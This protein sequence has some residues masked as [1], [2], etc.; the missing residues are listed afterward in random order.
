LLT[1]PLPPPKPPERTRSASA[2]WSAEAQDF[3]PF[4]AS[5][6]SPLSVGAEPETFSNVWLSL[7]LFTWRTRCPAG[8]AQL[9]QHVSGN[10]IHATRERTLDGS[11]PAA[12]EAFSVS[13][14]DFGFTDANYDC[15]N[16]VDS[17]YK[18]SYGGKGLGRF[19]WLKAFEHVESDSHYRIAASGLLHRPLCVYRQR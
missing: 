9:V 5:S 11:R 18:A 17:P 16:T 6:C 10:R 13:D 8:F 12:F 7:R 2:D 14:T 4:R 1:V 19:L 3:P 15:F